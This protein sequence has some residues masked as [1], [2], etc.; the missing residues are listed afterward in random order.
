MKVPDDASFATVQTPDPLPAALL[1]LAEHQEQLASL[2]GRLNEFGDRLQALERRRDEQ[3]DGT[4]S[5][6]PAPRW[7]L[8]PTSDRAEAVE[9]IAAWVDQVYERSYGHIAAMLAGCWREHDLCLFVLDFVSELHSLLY[10]RSARSARTLADQA[11]LTLRILP[12]AADLMR[13]ETARCDHTLAQAHSSPYANA[14]RRGT[15][16]TDPTAR[17]DTWSFTPTSGRP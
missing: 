6:I 1:A 9:R 12:A 5:P 10:L 11:E 3:P 2:G 13:A 17:V 7:W 14:P 15:G 8:L 4:Y 16:S